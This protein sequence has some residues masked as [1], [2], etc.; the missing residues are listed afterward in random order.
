MKDFFVFYILVSG[1]PVAR[2]L[3]LPSGLVVVGGGGL[4]SDG[5]NK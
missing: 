3:S 1:A 5:P 2:D 4:E